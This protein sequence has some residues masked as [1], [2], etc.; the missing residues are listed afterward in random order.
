MGGKLAKKIDLDGDLL[1]QGM[2]LPSK[3]KMEKRT[4]G[5]VEV[6]AVGVDYSSRTKARAAADTGVFELMVQIKSTIKVEIQLGGA[7]EPHTFGPF[8]TEDLG[9]ILDIGALDLTAS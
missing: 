7:S 5:T 8:K 4:L 9:E 6:T 1:H 2:Q 3:K